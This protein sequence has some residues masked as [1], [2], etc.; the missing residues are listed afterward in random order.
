MHRTVILVLALLLSAAAAAQENMAKAEQCQAKLKMANDAGLIVD[1]KLQ[2]GFV[3]VVV[4]R[5]AWR[6]MT[7]DQKT[8]LVET[9]ECLIT[10]GDASKAALI[11]VFDHIDNK[12]VGKY[13]GN[14][15]T[16]P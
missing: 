4:N 15:L 5:D 8:G 12:L 13:N 3:R 6:G 16:V 7:F 1:L 10:V 11:N 9:V 14:R 2:P